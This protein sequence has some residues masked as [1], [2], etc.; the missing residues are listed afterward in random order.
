V[1]RNWAKLNITVP[2]PAVA[3][4]LTN[5][6]T[7]PRELNVLRELMADSHEL[8]VK[9]SPNVKLVSQRRGTSSFLHRTGGR[10]G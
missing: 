1:Y 4:Y 7:D 5:T 8:S 10:W 6:G 3:I 9:H 2:E